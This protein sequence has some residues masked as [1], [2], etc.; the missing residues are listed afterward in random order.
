[1]EELGDN[2][3][4]SIIVVDNNEDYPSSQVCVNCEKNATIFCSQCNSYYCHVDSV[5]WK[6]I[7]SGLLP[8]PK[9]L[10]TPVQV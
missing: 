6:F 5:C 3:E 7:H 2:S 4:E 8:K 9:Q 10:H 1:M